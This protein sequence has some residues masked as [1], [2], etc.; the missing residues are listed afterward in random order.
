M[1]ILPHWGDLPDV[2]LILGVFAAFSAVMVMAVPSYTAKGV[3]FAAARVLTLSLA[4][5]LTYDATS[6]AAAAAVS[7]AFALTLAAQHVIRWL[8]RKRVQEVPFQQ[9]AVWLALAAQSI[10]PLSY[11]ARDGLPFVEVSDGG[12][13]VVLLEVALLL[14]SAGVASRVFAARGAG[15]LT[16]YAIAFGTLALGPLLQLRADAMNPDSFLAR[17]VL[18]HDG[19]VQ[20]LLGLAVAATVAGVFFRGQGLA[21]RS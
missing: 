8:M 19:V 17:P 13:W 5:V 1:L 9:A 10:L 18:S 3:Y 11:I 6:S 7:V 16:V 15:Y 14:V 4:V 2:E 12:C 20:M 21:V